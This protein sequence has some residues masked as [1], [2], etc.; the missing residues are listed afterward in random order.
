MAYHLEDID[1]QDH[2]RDPIMLV[3][4]QS[5]TEYYVGISKSHRDPASPNWRI[6]RIYKVGSI[7]KFEFPNGDQ[8]FKYIWDARFGYTY[9]P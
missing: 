3:D 6:K 4:E 5:S 8:T 9:L 7:W 2:V 1:V